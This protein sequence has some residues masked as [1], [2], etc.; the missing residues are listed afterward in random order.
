MRLEAVPLAL[1]AM[2]S[3][4]LLLSR[5]PLVRDDDTLEPLE[6]IIG[7]FPEG[8]KT[9]SG[10]IHDG[11]GGSPAHRSSAMG[12]P[13]ASLVV[14][15]HH[16]GCRCIASFSGALTAT[17]R[18]TID[19]VADL[20]ADEESVVLDFSR[21][22]VIDD[23]GAHAIEMLFRLVRVRGAIFRWPNHSRKDDP[24]PGRKRPFRVART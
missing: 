22:D 2:A 21:V 20:V 23:A 6:P 5:S 19:G 10:A 11:D 13:V 1:T 3:S 7:A 9:V 14:H 24:P 18:S 8:G 12:T 17:T 4:V 16:E 15:L